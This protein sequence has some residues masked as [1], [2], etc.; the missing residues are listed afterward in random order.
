MAVAKELT[1]THVK[2]TYA[3]DA[4]V[5]TQYREMMWHIFN[6]ILTAGGVV[7]SSCNGAGAYGNNDSINRWATSANLIWNTAGNNHSWVVIK[8]INRYMLIDLSTA[9]S[10]YCTI[11]FSDSKFYGG[12][13]T[14]R[15]TS[16]SSRAITTVSGTS[17]CC[18]QTTA[19]K[20]FQL[21]GMYHTYGMRLFISYGGNTGVCLLFENL[22]DVRN[23]HQPAIFGYAGHVTSIPILSLYNAANTYLGTSIAI[24]ELAQIGAGWSNTRIT[25]ASRDQKPDDYY[26]GWN[27]E[28]IAGT[29]D[30][31]QRIISDYDNA[32]NTALVSINLTLAPDAT[33]EYM[34]HPRTLSTA[35]GLCYIEAPY[36]NLGTN[37][38]AVS[39]GDDWDN[40]WPDSSMRII[41][42][43]TGHRWCRGRIQDM[44]WGASANANGQLFDTDLTRDWVQYGN[45]VVPNDG[46]VCPVT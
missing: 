15:P 30:G 46:T 9:S 8:F 36:S 22:T 1:W 14:A 23:V 13:A 45:F 17:W 19:N 2:S 35:T 7:Q 18:G 10:F 32:T 4:D 11:Q 5:L 25:L 41:S 26:N 38:A 29:N 3:G 42:A 44:Y 6:F 24:T 20:Q 34:L 21:H 16:T 39:T 40:T 43:N 27:V 33:S 12:T 28:I 37:P 31:N